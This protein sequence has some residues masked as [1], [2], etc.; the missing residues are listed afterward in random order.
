MK[1]IEIAARELPRRLSNYCN[2]VRA[3]K[4]LQRL[5]QQ[6]NSCQITATI[7][8]TARVANLLQQLLQQTKGYQMLLSRV[9][10]SCRE[11]GTLQHTAT[12]CNTLQHTATHCN[13]LQHSATPTPHTV[14]PPSRWCRC[15]RNHSEEGVGCKQPTEW[16]VK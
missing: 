8:A 7:T 16:T 4:L 2:R 9:L 11:S 15:C 12:Q 10:F 13:T 5:L 6:S 1:N 14:K 3:V